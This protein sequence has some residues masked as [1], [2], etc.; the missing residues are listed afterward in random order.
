MYTLIAV[1]TYVLSNLYVIRVINDNAEERT[2][3]AMDKVIAEIIK[4]A[5]PY[6]IK[7][8]DSNSGGKIYLKPGVYSEEEKHSKPVKYIDIPNSVFDDVFKPVLLKK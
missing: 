5:E 6:E 3:A 7:E 2:V 4:A 1:A 8:E